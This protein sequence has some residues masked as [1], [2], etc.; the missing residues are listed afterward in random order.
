MAEERIAAVGYINEQQ[1]HALISIHNA[2]ILNS[3]VDFVQ[4]AVSIDG[5][6]KLRDELNK[7]LARHYGDSGITNPT[8]AGTA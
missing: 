1:R 6:I 8:V 2:A 7:F 3:D 5:A 4:V